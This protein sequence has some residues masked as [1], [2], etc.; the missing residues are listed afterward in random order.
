MP[1]SDRKKEKGVI[2]EERSSFCLSTQPFVEG[3]YLHH[4]NYQLLIVK[5]V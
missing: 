4:S 3:H 5:T 2:S 1:L